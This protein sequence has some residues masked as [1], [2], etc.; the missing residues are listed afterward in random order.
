MAD[1][2]LHIKDSYYFEVP[3]LLYPYAYTSRTQFPDVWISLDPEFEDWEAERLLKALRPIHADLPPEEKVLEDWHHWTHADHANFAKPLKRFLSEKYDGNVAKF[4]KWKADAVQAARL[5]AVTKDADTAEAIKNAQDLKFEDYLEHVS[6]Q[7]TA[8]Q[9]YL[10]FLRWR[11]THATEIRQVAREAHDIREWKEDKNVAE[12]SNAKIDAYNAHLSGKIILSPQPFGRLANLYEPETTIIDQKTH[13]INTENF[14][15]CFSKYMVIELFVGLVLIIFFSQLAT[16]IQRG[17][18]P[19]GKLWN[20]LE[21][22][23]VFI[24]DQIV[25]PSLGGHHEEDHEHPEHGHEFGGPYAEHGGATDEHG[26]LRSEEKAGAAAHGHA[27]HPHPGDRFLPLLW[28]IFFFVL[29]CNLMGMLPW[30]GSPTAAFAVT[31]AMAGV[32]FLTVLI[33]GML[34]F[35]VLGFFLNQV[36]GMDL[37]WYMAIVI[38]PMILL[39]ELL[40]LCIKHGVLAVRLLANMVAGH[41]VILGIMALAFGAEAALTFSHEPT[42]KWGLTAVIAVVASAAFNV[43][44]LFVAFLQAY[45]ITFLSA[46][47]IGAAVHKH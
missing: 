27:Y 47:F 40:G 33:A 39:I 15:F 22:F 17:L 19:K 3:K 35:G 38:K 25:R 32:I 20:L 28:T 26:H 37:P 13:G 16:R 41:L 34:Q 29:G 14:G 31:A 12:W 1:P 6:T 5:K 46:L 10:P 18:P 42:W 7:D 9:H 45:I 4:D 21:V 24:R 23:L 36:P 8:D 11:H 43:L 30:A 2:V 44:E